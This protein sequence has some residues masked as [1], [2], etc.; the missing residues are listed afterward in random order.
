MKIFVAGAT[1]VAGRRTVR[2]L[3]AAGHRV[4][5]VA[6]SAEKAAL[7][8]T[9][10]ATPVRVDLFDAGA[11]RRAVEGHEVI[12]N[13]ATR[14]PPLSR[15]M[16][17][18]AWSENARIRAH[19]P[20]NF[21]DAGVATGASRYIQESLAFI[22]PDRGD[23]WIDEDVAVDPPPHARSTLVA[24]DRV[25]RFTDAGGSGVVLRF[26]Q[27]YAPDAS[28]T[29]SWIRLARRGLSP[30]VGPPL[31]FMPLVHADDAAASVLAALDAPAGTYN[32]VD[33]EPLTQGQLANALADSVRRDGL[34]FP[35]GSLLRIG[36]AK[37]RMLMRSQ[38]VSN[39]RFRDV[40]MWRPRWRTALEGFPAVVREMGTADV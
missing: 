40:T 25:E 19:T 18:G 14:I 32:V 35:P 31:A 29:A 23:D 13:L 34:R 11:V 8:R 4:T 38:R 33:D 1:G 37:V 22:Y 6:R 9:L 7:V 28:H 20:S 2:L 27:F 30:F 36:G 17:P 3:V 26:G 15:S 16:L 5:A 21:V 24:E 10:D 39:Q 12:V